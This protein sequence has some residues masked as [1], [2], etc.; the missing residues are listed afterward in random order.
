MDLVTK[1]K[2]NPGIKKKVLWCLIP[3]GEARPRK[4]V[5]ALIN[6]F[7]HQRGKGS[8]IRASVR[9]DVLP[10]NKFILGNKAVIEDYCVINNGMGDVKIGD[11]SFIGLNNTLIGP[12]EIGQNV[13][14]AQQVVISG[15][16]HGYEAVEIP[17]KDQPCHTKPIVVKDDC[18]IGAGAIITAGVTIGKHAVVAAGS[19]V[20]R[21]VPDYTVVAGNPAR[22]IKSYNL[23]TAQWEKV[24]K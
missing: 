15:L 12:L 9:R 6:P 14:T 22:V 23:K 3:S 13:I 19:I 20:T 24:Q 21:D 5:S 1:I 8:V 2:A 4:W 17:I 18:W 7:F 16:N 11:N 10:F